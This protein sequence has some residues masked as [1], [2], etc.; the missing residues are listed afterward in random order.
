MA[1]KGSRNTS[2]IME[3]YIE[4]RGVSI[5]DLQDRCLLLAF[6]SQITRK[7]IFGTQSRCFMLNYYLCI[8]SYITLAWKA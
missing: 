2:A 7:V 4:L 1:T 6:N 8:I 5:F 3:L